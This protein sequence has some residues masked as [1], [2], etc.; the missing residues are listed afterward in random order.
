MS[1]IEPY[2][3][4]TLRVDD[5][6]HELLIAEI[7]DLGF[8]G[9]EQEP[10]HLVAYL[11]QRAYAASMEEEL[12]QKLKRW[13][14]EFGVIH[15]QEHEPKNWNEI[16]EA[17]IKPVEAGAFF[18]IPSWY[19][20]AINTRVKTLVIEPKMAFGTGHH[21]TTKLMLEEISAIDCAG[22]SV[23]DVGTGT[24][25]LAIAALV[26]GA[27]H[28]FGFD[29]DEW[30]EQNAQENA[31][32]NGVEDRFT[33]KIGSF[34]TVAP[35]QR[36]DLVLAN[37]QRHIILENAE[38][39]LSTVKKGGTLLLSGI[40]THEVDQIRTSSLFRNLPTPKVK[41]MGE[42]VMMHYTS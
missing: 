31:V 16:W 5:E 15:I 28:A 39:L 32:L 1:T 23:L 6:L 33:I 25:V 30:S 14:K 21:E 20:G 13:S 2:L 27:Q 19:N 8:E 41:S 38:A 3:A 11:P 34:E 24:G 35:E 36:F 29:I 4:L 12:D 37:L 17:S 18:L 9:F 42:W 7:M 22:K 40:L 26:Q 10:Q